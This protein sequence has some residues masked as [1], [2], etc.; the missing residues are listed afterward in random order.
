MTFVSE[1]PDRSHFSVVIAENCL[2]DVNVDLDMLKKSYPN[3]TVE[4]LENKQVFS[5][6]DVAILPMMVE[7]QHSYQWLWKFNEFV[8]VII[9]DRDLSVPKTASAMQNGVVDVLFKPVTTERI[10]LAVERAVFLSRN[11]GLTSHRYLWNVFKAMERMN[12]C[13][14]EMRLMHIFCNTIAK[15]TSSKGVVLYKKF[16]QAWGPVKSIL[17]HGSGPLNRSE[18]LRLIQAVEKNNPIEAS[19]ESARPREATIPGV[20]PE[21]VRLPDDFRI[22]G[23]GTLQNLLVILIPSYVP[24][25][26]VFLDP[27]TV[28]QKRVS[29]EILGSFA[30]HTAG[31]LEAANNY[32]KVSELVYIDDVTG[33]YN[34]RYL[35]VV[36][37]NRLRLYEKDKSPFC[38]LFIDIDR[39]KQVN[40]T[41]GHLVGSDVLVKVGHVIRR[42]VRYD[43]AVF[44]YGGD[45]FVVVLTNADAQGGFGSAERIRR[46]I[47]SHI[48]ET[49]GQRIS[50][51]ASIGVAAFP[52]HGATVQ[53]IVEHADKAMYEGK[54]RSRNIVLLCDV[55]TEQAA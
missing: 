2:T 13:H 14:D 39:F 16:N 3:L 9:L 8:Q 4:S 35:P 32:K 17:P 46:N 41:H 47:E 12:Q 24:I 6:A 50:V 15:E 10:M 23:V 48:F 52:Q 51:T 49:Y 45:E 31:A 19:L 18:C 1:K 42:S 30:Y 22:F 34:A 38:V 21:Y 25:L 55:T 5:S 28:M 37:E 40:D 33:L 29:R 44:R 11:P 26:C 20:L 27:P 43:D 36:L 7:G 53:A 54:R